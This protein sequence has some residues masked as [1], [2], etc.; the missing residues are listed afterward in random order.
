MS[1]NLKIIDNSLLTVQKYIL[2]EY[3]NF[4]LIPSMTISYIE[5]F[6][7]SYK[8]KGGTAAQ[9]VGSRHN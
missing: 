2:I 3:T 7:S 1:I 4:T 8:E 5:Q 9:T 6:L